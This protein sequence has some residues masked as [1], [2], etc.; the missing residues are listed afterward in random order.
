MSG[1][2]Q[3]TMLGRE[4]CRRS[5]GTVPTFPYC[6]SASPVESNQFGVAQPSAAEQV[7]G[8]SYREVQA[9]LAELPDLLDVRK[10]ANAAG[11]GDRQ[12]RNAAKQRHKVGVD[13]C[14]A[15]LHCGGVDEKFAATRGQLRQR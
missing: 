3:E 9:V 1:L 4:G 2:A 8:A 5:A 15:A 10:A 7:E 14:L 6:H 11:V 13:T 12:G